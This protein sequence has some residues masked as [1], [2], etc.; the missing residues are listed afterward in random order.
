MDERTEALALEY[1][2]LLTQIYGLIDT[3]ENDFG[4]EGAVRQVAMLRN[5]GNRSAYLLHHAVAL[6]R[7]RGATWEAIGHVLGVTRQAAQQRY[8]DPMSSA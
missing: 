8:Y 1:S 2:D 4:A 7:E 3:T 6:S 5:L